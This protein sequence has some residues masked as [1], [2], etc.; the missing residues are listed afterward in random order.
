MSKGASRHSLFS[1]RLD[2]AVFASYFL[3]GIVPIIALFVVVDTWVLPQYADDPMRWGWLVGLGFL[4]V[5]SLAVFFALRHV[6][7][8]AHAQMETDNE[9]LQ[10]LFTA[11]RELSAGS[12]PE[13]LL[14]A[15][16][17]HARTVSNADH[18]AI[19]YT[20]KEGE[21]PTLQPVGD[22]HGW[23][24]SHAALAEAIVE[25][26]LDSGAPAS[27]R[28]GTDLCAVPF[29]RPAGQRGA[30]VWTGGT[31]SSE[32]LDG[33]T[34]LAGIASTAIERGDLE[35]AQRNFFAHVTDLLVN[36]L[37]AH[38]V[39]RHG[40]GTGVAR[41]CNRIAHAVGLDAREKE[42]LHFAAMLHDIGML[43]IEPSRHTDPKAVRL[44]PV[45]GARMLE[46]IRLW[47]PLAPVVR[48]HHE[49]F[50]G[51]GYP[52]GL[53]GDAIPRNARIIGLADA[54]DAMRRD[55]PHRVAL[56]VA[57]VLEELQDHR[58][59][60]FDPELV[61]VFRDLVEK[62]ELDV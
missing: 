47:E 58:G 45:V 36:A 18:L 4:A 39:G 61:D 60:Q 49:W 40:H 52:E 62:G 29:A 23:F 17:T 37:D 32:A 13:T 44:H 19:W 56:S 15:T 38:V 54:V 30:I 14:A 57:D 1:Q 22:G 26:A 42:R 7:A 51:G 16:A 43:K 31:T 59:S 50:D 34:T 41:I 55:E 6:T 11:S 3:G 9:R 12:D 28:G 21:A 33:L 20:A 35:D 24:E 48:T 8:R 25:E 5:L 2:R 46:R 27:A 53:S 10:A